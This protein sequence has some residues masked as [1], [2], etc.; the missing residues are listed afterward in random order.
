MLPTILPLLRGF[1]SRVTIRFCMLV[2][3]IVML[4]FHINILWAQDALPAVDQTFPIWLLIPLFIG[5]LAHWLKGYVRGSISTN[6]W[7]Y[8]ISNLGQTVS[9]VVAAVGQLF[10]AWAAGTVP[11][12]AGIFAMA[13]AVFNIGY[14][15][16]S[17][18][19]GSGPFIK[20]KSKG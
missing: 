20:P 15:S 1:L 2:L 5:M 3:F 4:V 14:V 10:G 9:A 13:W 16:D 8:F 18:L 19:N 17:T 7:Q 11:V 12:D 6:I